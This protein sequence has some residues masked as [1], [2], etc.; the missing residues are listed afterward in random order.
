MHNFQWLI[1]RAWYHLIFTFFMGG[2]N[3]VRGCFLSQPGEISFSFFFFLVKSTFLTLHS[4]D[5]PFLMILELSRS[6]WA[7]LNCC[8]VK[9]V[10]HY[11]LNGAS[12]FNPQLKF[13]FNQVTQIKLPAW[14]NSNF[15]F[16]CYF[17]T[18]Q[19]A[20]QAIDNRQ[21]LFLDQVSLVQQKK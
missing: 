18:F 7:S 13:N 3:Y 20:F 17:T 4:D 2:K 16:L 11:K 6:F 9:K 10:A 1:D 8:F 19:V 12:D 21:E 15:L 5:I 14:F